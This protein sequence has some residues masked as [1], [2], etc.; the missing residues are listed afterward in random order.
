MVQEAIFNL[1][2]QR[3]YTASGSNVLYVRNIYFNVN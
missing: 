2:F 1:A 3:I